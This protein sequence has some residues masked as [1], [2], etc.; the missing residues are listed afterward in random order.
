M[1]FQ[2]HN[3]TPKI[4]SATSIDQIQKQ[5]SSLNQNNEQSLPNAIGIGLAASVAGALAWALITYAIEYQIGFMAIGI[6]WLV[7]IAVNKFGNSSDIQFGIVG[8]LFSLFGCLFGNLLATLFFV[9]RVEEISIFAI[10][11]D[12]NFDIIGGIFIDTFNPMDLLFYGL[13]VYYG[14]KYSIAV[15]VASN[16]NQTPTTPPLQN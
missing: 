8:A 13:A 7:G 11:S 10:F 15:P 12:L 9:A 4:D 2:P 5:L 16:K 3:Q 1:S 14:F 6:G